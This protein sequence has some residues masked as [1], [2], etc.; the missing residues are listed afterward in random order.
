MV[1]SLSRNL[2]RGFLLGCWAGATPVN[3]ND[4]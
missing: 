2:Q 1:L 4:E 3:S